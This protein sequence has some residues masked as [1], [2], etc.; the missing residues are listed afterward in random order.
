M[1]ISDKTFVFLIFI[2]SLA[3]G[4]VFHIKYLTVN[5][6]NGIRK[7]KSEIRKYKR[8]CRILQAEWQVVSNPER[9]QKLANKYLNASSTMVPMK[10]IC[11]DISCSDENHDVPNRKNKL[12]NLINE[13]GKR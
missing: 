6:E 10:V 7:T 11:R 3:V 8:E 4:S 13:V 12:I 1:L 5:V 2:V 9:I